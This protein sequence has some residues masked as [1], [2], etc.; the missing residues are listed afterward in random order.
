VPDHLLGR[1]TLHPIT[2]SERDRLNFDFIRDGT[3]EVLILSRPQRSAKG[4]LLSP[5]SLWPADETVHNRDRIPAHA[6]SESDRLLARPH[7]AGKLQH[8]SQSQRCWRS[9]QW[10]S[11][12]GAH[13][14]LVTPNHPA[15]EAALSRIQSTTGL[16]RLLRDPLGFVWRYAL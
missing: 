16:Q 2:I 9:W 15:I 6:F 13:D 8:V 1:R 5:S 3:R 10:E 7:D 14:G 11:K 12:L 4:S